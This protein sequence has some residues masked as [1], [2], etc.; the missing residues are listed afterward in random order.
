MGGL[1]LRVDQSAKITVVLQPGEMREVVQVTDVTPLLEANTSSLGQVIENKKILDLPLNGRNPFGLGLLAGNTT[2]MFGMGSNLP[3]IGGGGRFSANEVMLDGVDNNTTVNSGAIGRSGIA[4]TPSVDAVQEF[5]VKTSA[6][7]A[8]FGHSAGTVI[9]ASVKSGTNEF[10]GVLFEFLRNDKLDANNFFTNSAGL[11]RAQF[12]Q[13]QFGGALGGPI[14]SNRTFFFVDYQGTRRRSA[15]GTSILDVPPEDFRSGDFSRLSAPI[16]DPNTRRVGPAGTVIADRFPNNRIP[17]SRMNPASVEITKLVPS[18]NFGSPG[19]QSRNFFRQT[20]RPF[21]ADQWDLRID[22]SIGNKDNLFGRFF[23]GN[24]S[25][26]NPGVFDGFIGGGSSNID[27]AR[28]LVLSDTHIFTPTAVNEFRFGYVRH[29]GSILG[30]APLG[31]EF[32]EKNRVALFPFPERGFPSIAFNFSGAIS[33]SQ[34]FTSWG[35]G[36]SNLNIENRFHWADNINITRGNHT[37]KTGADVRR[38]RFETLKGSPFFGE[39]V[40]GSIFTSSSDSPGSGAPL[41]DFLL[42][43]PSTIQGTQ[44]LDWGR[45]REIYFGAYFQDDWKVTRKLT[46]NLGIRYDLYTQPVDARD[47]GSLFDLETGRFALP[48]KDGFSR[49]IVDG[50]HNNFGPRLGFA[51]Q[52]A[53]KLVVRT[54]Y[55]IFYGLRDQNQEVTQFS[56]NNP[57]TPT[58]FLPSASSRTLTCIG[59]AGA[60]CNAGNAEFGQLSDGTATGRQIQFGLKLLF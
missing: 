34:Q 56:G 4:Y 51:Y 55:G 3:F 16:F 1:E 40:F 10:H 47:R 33:G 11:P 8:E 38:T 30:D 32:A 28:H 7:S 45:Q 41:A 48:G 23:F 60:P 57:N 49:A 21:D 13:N 26:P 20:P 2:P 18:P 29:N 25:G 12:Q 59:P 50:D 37:L 46:L 44:M 35:G 5:K 17:A 39:F 6:F 58:F 53:S 14:L 43:F 52:F 27:N 22:H 24:Q 54:G 9:N 42:G 31:V 15:A 36:S 19:A